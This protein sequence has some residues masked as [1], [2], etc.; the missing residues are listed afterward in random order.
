[1][2][3][4][5]PNLGSYA[6]VQALRGVYAVV[7]KIARM[8]APN[9]SAES[10]AA[11]VFSTFPALYHLLPPPGFDD[12][13]DFFDPDAWPSSGPRPDAKL[14]E[15]ARSLSDQLATP[16]D[17]FTNVV[18]VGQETVTRVSR[19]K[20]GFVYTITRQGD[21]TVPLACAALPGARTY[22]TK[23]AHSELARD[24]AVAQALTEI[25]RSS[26][27]TRRLETKWSRGSSAEARITDA[28]LRRTHVSKVDWV[29]M[30]PDARQNFLRNL[31]E[32]PQ[33][34]LRIPGKTVTSSRKSSSSAAAAPRRSKALPR[35]QLAAGKSR[36]RAKPAKTSKSRSSGPAT[37]PKRSKPSPR[38]RSAARKSRT[39]AKT[40]KSRSPSAAAAPKRSNA[41]RR[42][43]SAATKSRMATS[44][45]ARAASSRKASSAVASRTRAR[46]L[47]RKRR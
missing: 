9:Q 16:D 26:G 17:R 37:T 22:Y 15:S 12:A 2:L 7:R 35:A 39:A 5:A 42:A 30:D 18:G 1:V 36:D 46:S 38:A 10:L 27:E 47:A 45:R 24:P 44:S 31:N 19:Q 21:G 25:L 20:D 34:E 29:H 23:V 8:A 40:S 4:G 28:E 11:D 6:P 14:L 33:L 32:P 13:V 41:S 43:Q 3:L